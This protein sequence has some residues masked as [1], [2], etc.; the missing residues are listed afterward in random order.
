MGKVLVTLLHAEAAA[1]TVADRD[2][3]GD[4]SAKGQWRPYT[5]PAGPT[6]P[7]AGVARPRRVQL[8]VGWACLLET[9]LSLGL[10]TRRVR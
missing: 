8:D 4:G 7:A 3:R 2:G 9:S 5:A 1:T 6:R 10:F